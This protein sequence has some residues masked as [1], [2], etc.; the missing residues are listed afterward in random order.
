MNIPGKLVI[1][2]PTGAGSG[3]RGVRLSTGK[4]SMFNTSS[5]CLE[6]C[7]HDDEI[8]GGPGEAC[9]AYHRESDG[10]TPKYVS[11]TFEGITESGC[12]EWSPSVYAHFHVS[13]SVGPNGTFVLEQISECGWQG[14]FA[15]TGTLSYAHQEA[16]CTPDPYWDQFTCELQ[17]FLVEVTMY[18][19]EPDRGI[20][21]TAQYLGVGPICPL[22]H[23]YRQTVDYADQVTDLRDIGMGASDDS[24]T[25]LFTGGIASIEA[26]S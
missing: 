22:G 14:Y 7:G 5:M 19:F 23:S 20:N 13:P 26:G 24:E 10:F 9:D 12:S 15:V 11:V 21:V 1:G 25:L 2:F 4:A 8:T 18:Y 16:T 6:C 3:K 17:W